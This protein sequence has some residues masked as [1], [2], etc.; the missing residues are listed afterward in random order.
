[1]GYKSCIAGALITYFIIGVMARSD[2]DSIGTVVNAIS[3]LKEKSDLV[4]LEYNSTT[5]AT[6]TYQNY[7]MKAE[8]SSI[9]SGS[10]EFKTSLNKITY[11]VDYANKKISVHLS[12]TF[13]STPNIDSTTIKNYDNGSW[14]LLSTDIRDNMRNQN[15]ISARKFFM[16]DAKKDIDIAHKH[17]IYSIYYDLLK[18]IE[19]TGVTVTID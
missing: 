13:I 10:V 6:S 1:M 19:K 14:L 15:I 3:Q 9:I 11:N 4:S 17:A 7:K 2:W 16:D 5:V 8:L 18:P 12:K